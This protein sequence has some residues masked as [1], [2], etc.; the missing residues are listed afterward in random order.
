M[1][2][3][4]R[5]I[6]S[7]SNASYVLERDGQTRCTAEVPFSIA[8]PEITLFRR[9]EP[10]LKITPNLGDSVKKMVRNGSWRTVP[11]D[12]TDANGAQI[13]TLAKIREGT[14]LSSNYYTELRI[15]GRVLQ[16]YEVGLGKEGMRYPV[17]EDGVQL[18]QVEKEPVVLDNLDAY[19]L[20]SL[21][22]F[23]ELAALLFA[24]FLDFHSYR[25]AGERTRGKK[26]FQYVYT[27]RKEILSKYDPDFRSRCEIH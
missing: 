8:A 4:L 2:A 19:S 27:R 11:C 17:Y 18:S 15:G 22:D 5:Q 13:G 3:L 20:C 23:G 25:N 10:W 9:E 21:D 14:F 24:L 1:I 12:I 7:G 26:S 6:R 16:I